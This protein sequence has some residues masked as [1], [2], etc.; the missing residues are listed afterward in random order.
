MM[1]G[2]PV[3]PSG[4][5]WEGERPRRAA[6]SSSEAGGGQGGEPWGRNAR[7]PPCPQSSAKKR[8]SPTGRHTKRAA[9]KARI[10]STTTLPRTK[11]EARGRGQGAGAPRGDCRP[12]K[13]CS[14]GGGGDTFGEH[15]TRRV[16][17]GVHLC[18]FYCLSFLRLSSLHAV[19]DSC[20]RRLSFPASGKPFRQKYGREY[21]GASA[22]RSS[23]IVRRRGPSLRES[24]GGA[25]TSTVA[26]GAGG[27]SR[28]GGLPLPRGLA[29]TRAFA[30]RDVFLSNSRADHTPGFRGPGSM[31]RDKER[32]RANASP[33]HPPRFGGLGST[34]HRSDGAGRRR[35]LVAT[36]F[37]DRAKVFQEGHLS[38]PAGPS[39]LS[40]ATHWWLRILP[41]GRR[42]FKRG[43]F[44]HPRGLPPF[45]EQHTH[46]IPETPLT[47]SFVSPT[48][49]PGLGPTTTPPHIRPP[50]KK[51]ATLRHEDAA[52][53][54]D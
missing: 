10:L 13:R 23:R 11:D 41:T 25:S 50:H 47:F 4:K 12:A 36:Y 6:A 31:R 2:R 24:V 34:C 33:L 37:A 21:A 35:A 14:Q 42:Y 29:W 38:T 52:S 1:W 48:V 53:I 54:V 43:T 40:R 19:V 30:C 20:C 26:L 7:P 27:G 3:A 16:C 8:R 28:S 9:S 45:Q 22:L 5:T 15:L 46:P 44:T 17:T 39:P 49:L 32:D 18:L 51:G